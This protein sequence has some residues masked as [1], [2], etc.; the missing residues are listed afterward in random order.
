MVD[1]QFRL[2]EEAAASFLRDVADSIE[3]GEVAL[4]GDDWKVYQEIK[5]EIFARVFSDESG[6]ELA[7]K[8]PRDQEDEE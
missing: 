4:D 6:L 2:D 7:I 8:L 1:K 5:Q 3:E